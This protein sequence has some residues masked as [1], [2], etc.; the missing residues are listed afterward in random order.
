MMNKLDHIA[1]R[2]FNTPVLLS[3]ARAA[4]LYSYL[5][6][7]V[8]ASTLVLATGEQ[9]NND[10]CKKVADSFSPTRAAGTY[11]IDNGVAIVPVE[12]SLV[13]KSGYIGAESGVMGYDGIAAQLDDAA[14]NPMV[15]GVL[16]DVNSGGGEVS[17]CE[18]LAQ[19]IATFNK[20]IWA[21]SNELAASAAYWL[22]SAANKVHITNTAEV[23][24]VGVVIVH[25]D[26]SKQIEAEGMKITI[27]HSGAN[28]VDGNPYE[29]L[30]DSVR[31]DFQSQTDSLR[32]LFA[33]A[34]AKNRGMKLDAVLGTEARVYRGDEAVKIG[35]A[36]K[37]S[38]FDNTLKEFKSF[39]TSSQG[40]NQ[41]VRMDN[42][43]APAAD[44]QN[45]AIAAA[46]KQG[47]T[48]GASQERAR[49]SAIL[50]ADSAK[51]REAQASHLALKTDMAADAAVE[52]LATFPAAKKE[53]ES[54]VDLSKAMATG[55]GVKPVA[56]APD[57]K[58]GMDAAFENLIKNLKGA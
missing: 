2:V 23:G 30:P 44:G 38:S 41:G 18:S 24:S 8:G 46:T 54:V 51:G 6:T 4:V 31:L 20:P 52:F 53:A 21:I 42:N 19:K 40:R 11:R 13:H 50:G 28:K 26:F 39:L 25:A 29:A 10:A 56:D 34:V 55:A 14:K 43:H 32:Q 22:A 12:G 58:V 49:I 37:V 5:S 27:I 9:L 1:Q 15:K 7:R 48:L 36:D 45:E 16:L 35:F 47:T 3:E 17:G 33:G 57:V